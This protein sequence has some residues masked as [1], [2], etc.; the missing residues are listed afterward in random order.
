MNTSN[1]QNI[2]PTL[3]DLLRLEYLV[4]STGFS[5]LPKQPVHSVLAGKHSSKLRGRGLDFEEVRKYVAS[6]DIRNI[7]W[8][9]TARTRTT[10]TKVFTEE[11][12]K[13]V[14]AIVDLTPGMFFG[15]QVY[16]KSFIASQLAAITAFKVLKNGDR[17]G[18]II[19]NNEETKIFSPQR[20]RKVVLQYLKKL[21]DNCS[22]LATEKP[23]IKSKKELLEQT[24]LKTVSL[25]T[26]D[27]LIIVISDFHEISNTGKKHLIQ[28]AKHNDVILSR[29]TDPMEE[30]LPKDKL[31]LSDGDL[32][33]LWNFKKK[34]SGEKYETIFKKEKTGFFD[35]MNKYGIPVMELN[36]VDAIDVQLKSL[37][38]SK[39]QARKK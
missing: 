2:I 29:I 22:V 33:L 11:K 13:P 25:A 36:T 7:D 1:N 37:F 17:F 15:S 9:V 28:L 19:F 21:V 24:L 20:S 5:L 12:E 35:D 23:L 6:D 31:V 8:R 34:N 39:L 14:L 16:T 32:Q 38:K 27:Y 3:N 18:G 26:H 10:H 4:A 30:R